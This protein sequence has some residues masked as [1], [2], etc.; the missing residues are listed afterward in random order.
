MTNEIAISQFGQNIPAE[1]KGK[2]EFV[3]NLAEGVSSF[4]PR[5]QLAKDR[6]QITSP[7][8]AGGKGATHGNFYLVKGAEDPIVDL[9]DSVDAVICCVRLKA[10]AWKTGAASEAIKSD[11]KY[12]LEGDGNDE[13]YDKYKANCD[14]KVNE[15]DGTMY[16]YGPEF[17]LWLND[18]NCFATLFC[19][20]FRARKA[21][22]EEIYP[23]FADSAPMSGNMTVY[24]HYLSKTKFPG[25]TLKGRKCN[26][27]PAN[28]PDPELLKQ[29][30]ESFRKPRNVSQAEAD[31]E[32]EDR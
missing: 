26:T 6:S 15:D 11:G 2:D 18:H 1:N 13:L 9:T 25:W 23:I 8:K 30:V 14:N 3:T 12:V 5:V 27:P 16:D 22:Y 24:S 28:V 4:L 21:A 32:A 31:E 17:L 29:V 19:N 10:L 7:E 20:G